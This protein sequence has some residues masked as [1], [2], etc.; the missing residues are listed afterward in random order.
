MIFWILFLFYRYPAGVNPASCPDYP[1]CG[2][3][4][5]ASPAFHSGPSYNSAQYPAGVNPA[6]CPNY[7]YCN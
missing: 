2:G 7:P 1:Y 5:H 4:A 6:V 3:R